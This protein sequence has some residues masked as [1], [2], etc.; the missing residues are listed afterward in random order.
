MK[1]VCQIC[2]REFPKLVGLVTHI[3]RAEHLTPSEY[4]NKFIRADV[5]EGFCVVCG[6]DTTFTTLE[7]GYKKHCSSKCAANDPDKQLKT[8]NTCL[9]KYGTEN[10]AQNSEIKQKQADTLQLRYGV[11]HYSKTNEFKDKWKKTCQEK[12]GVD[13]PN[14]SPEIRE[15]SKRTCIDR[16]GVDNA[17]KLDSVK[18]QKTETCMKT[19]GVLHPMQSEEVK[20]KSR[21]T[22]L[23]KYGTDHHMKSPEF[24][25]KFSEICMKNHGV[26]Y[27]L[28]SEEVQ[29]KI[30]RTNL[31]KYGFEVASRNKEIRDRIKETNLKKYGAESV[32]QVEAY[33]QP[34]LEAKKRNFAK[35]LFYG[36]RLNQLIRPNFKE[37]EFTG[38]EPVY[39]WICNMCDTVFDGHL[40]DG[41]IP[42]CPKC[43][44]TTVSR[45][46]MQ[47]REFIQSLGLEG[48][49][50]NRTILDGKEIDICIPNYKLTIE[51]NGI[52]WHS[53]EITRMSDIWKTKFLVENG[54]RHIVV[55][56]DDFSDC[57]RK[58]FKLIEELCTFAIVCTD[59]EYLNNIEFFTT[60]TLEEIANVNINWILNKG[61]G[62]LEKL[63]RPSRP[64][65]ISA[66][67]SSLVES[68]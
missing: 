57:F 68:I 5:S 15:K 6:K 44:P 65:F 21:E 38:C 24:Q 36:D 28:L 62:E 52:Y 40:H 56:E 61:N 53:S 11:P 2:S 41:L 39:S 3:R 58:D 43:H 59:Q 48:N 51:Y 50:N 64:V 4:Y 12:F 14:Q 42:K 60:F 22:S 46:E 34:I 8:K 32:F 20:A 49:Q 45:G 23:T 54:Y 66:S 33:Q 47:L 18:K 7:R 1:Y 27:I 30:K 25:A 31:I 55:W 19:H 63:K 29:E 10:P 17:N 37:E 67:S 16:Y 26:P 9:K 13:N 35:K